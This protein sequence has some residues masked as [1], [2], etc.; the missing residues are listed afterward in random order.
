MNKA[1]RNASLLIGG[2]GLAA[3]GGFVLQSKFRGNR[4]DAAAIDSLWNWPFQDLVGGEKRLSAWRGK[5]LVVNFWATWCEPCREEIPTLV[6]T[7]S[8]YAVNGLQMVGISID[9]ASKVQ[10]FSKEYKVQYPLLIAGIDVIEITR[11]L[12]NKA[13]GLPYTVVLS[14]DGAI[15]ARHLGGISESQLELAIAPLLGLAGKTL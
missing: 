1:R 10:E 7:Q 15:Q 11:N 13:A 5:V 9:S 8:K 2:A 4:Q 14:R 3:I 12:G 6:R